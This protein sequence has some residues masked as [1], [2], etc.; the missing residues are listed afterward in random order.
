MSEQDRPLGRRR[1]LTGVVTLAG[2]QLGFSV[3]LRLLSVPFPRY[4]KVVPFYRRYARDTM[5]SVLRRERFTV[6]EGS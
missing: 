6:G 5:H 2:L 4:R 1:Y 3:A